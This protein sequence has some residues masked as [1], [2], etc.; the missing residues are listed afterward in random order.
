MSGEVCVSIPHTFL[1]LSRMV[2]GASLP[3]RCTIAPTY[4]A[5]TPLLAVGSVS[6]VCPSPCFALHIVS[7]CLANEVLLLARHF[8]GVAP[9]Q[10]VCT[11]IPGN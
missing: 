5:F 1:E 10:F 6:G 8:A 9:Q 3:S 4:I 11:Y 2:L 7:V